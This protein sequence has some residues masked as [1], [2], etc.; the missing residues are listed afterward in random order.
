MGD[1][2]G[3]RPATTI[4][5]SWALVDH[6]VHSK[7]QWPSQQAGATAQFHREKIMSNEAKIV[8]WGYARSIGFLPTEILAAT[9]TYPQK[10]CHAP[11]A[12]RSGANAVCDHYLSAMVLIENN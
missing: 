3:I 9:L 10:I 7:A 12:L 6:G 4:L 1:S 11:F 8:R 5:K 2:K